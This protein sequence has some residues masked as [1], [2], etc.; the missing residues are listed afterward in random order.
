[1]VPWT[2]N[3]TLSNF[4]TSDKSVSYKWQQFGSSMYR[5]NGASLS[6]PISQFMPHKKEFLSLYHNNNVTVDFPQKMG[7]YHTQKNTFPNCKWYIKG[8]V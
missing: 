4:Y 3:S 2:S 7:S 5:R 6:S 8:A 1:M